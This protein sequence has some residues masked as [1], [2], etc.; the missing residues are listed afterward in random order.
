MNPLTQ[1]HEGMEVYDSAGDKLGTVDMIKMSDEIPNN[2]IPEQVSVD[3]EIEKDTSVFH[4][5]IKI[6]RSDD[7]PEEIYER[8]L[9]KG[10]VRVDS[11]HLFSSDRYFTPE[12]I[13][14]VSN[15]EISLSVAKDD[16][17]KLH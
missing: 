11:A 1:I 6:F 2:G 5:L 16:L 15:E 4:E 12:Q 7:V 14:S 9:Q 13:S 3:S 10:F 8:L 17:I